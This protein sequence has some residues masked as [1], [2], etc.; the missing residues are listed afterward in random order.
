MKK[1]HCV[2]A[3]L[4]L[5]P[6][7]ASS[8]SVLL[9]ENFEGDLS[10]WDPVGYGIQVPDPLNPANQ[11]LSFSATDDSGNMWSMPLTVASGVTYV[12]EFK[13]L[14][15]AG[16]GD[17]GGYL[18]LWDPVLQFSSLGPVWGTQP[19]NSDYELIDDGAWHSYQLTFT[20]PE[21]FDPSSGSIQIVVE[22]WN[23][24][25]GGGW[26]PPNIAGDAFFDD[27]Q[28]YEQGA[29]GN[30]ALTWGTVKTLYR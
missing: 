6:I 13:Y 26:A 7:L 1:W 20:V 21:V 12:F 30:V 27:I 5:I 9:D 24:A 14:G 17:T 10:N 8:Q 19:E 2:T 11:V 18:W 4:I 28:F 3:L 23:G 25:A 22:D 16:G 15:N 29:V